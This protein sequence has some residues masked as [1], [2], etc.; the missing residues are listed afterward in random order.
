MSSLETVR[1]GI[2]RTRQGNVPVA[3]RPVDRTFVIPAPYTTMEDGDRFNNNVD[4][5]IL[6]FSTDESLN[7]LASADDWFMDET[8]KVAPPQF[9]QL[10]TMH[11]L[12]GT[13][14]IIGCYELLP[15][16][17]RETYMELL[18]QVNQLTNGFQP[19]TDYEQA[20]ICAIPNVYP[21]TS[22]KQQHTDEVFR[23][24]IRMIAALA[25]VPMADILQLFDDH[26]DDPLMSPARY[27]SRINM[28][29]GMKP[30]KAHIPQQLNSDVVDNLK[31]VKSS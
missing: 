7:F 15:N 26:S 27:I 16:K 19:Q 31:M 11:G 5:R 18:Q 1:S 30:T 29:K 9:A 21:N 20:G 17:T 25:F 28:V 14:H 2:R 8:F 13:H 6:I 12:S 24:N 4:D 22:Q 23:N 3:P 10:Y